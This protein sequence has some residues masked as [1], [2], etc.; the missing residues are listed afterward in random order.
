MGSVQSFTVSGT[1]SDGES[2]MSSVVDNSTFGDD[3]ANGGSATSWSFEYTIDASDNNNVTIL[4]TATD[5]VGNTNTTIYYFFEDNTAPTAIG[6][7]YCHADSYGDNSTTDNDTLIFFDWVNV[8]DSLSGLNA[9]FCEIGDATPDEDGGLDLQDTDTGVNGTNTY[10]VW[11][12]DNV[13]NYNSVVNDT[14]TITIAAAAAGGGEETYPVDGF[15]EAVIGQAPRLGVTM[16]QILFI[17]L[18]CVMV[19]FFWKRVQRN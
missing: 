3:P 12:R 15:R 5:N 8:T 11:A 19:I 7:A 9:F 2:A 14:I 17:V 16:M 13:G 6:A 1:A 4:Y 18:M 10:F